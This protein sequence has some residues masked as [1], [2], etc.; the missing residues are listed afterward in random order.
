MVGN[1]P[2]ALWKLSSGFMLTNVRCSYTVHVNWTWTWGFWRVFTGSANSK[3]SKTFLMPEC[4]KK[5]GYR[6][7]T[8]VEVKNRDIQQ[9]SSSITFHHF[10]PD[11]LYSAEKTIYLR[12]RC[13]NL[14]LCMT[15]QGTR[16]A[17]IGDHLRSALSWVEWA[18]QTCL[19]A[20]SPH[21][22]NI[23]FKHMYF[24]LDFHFM[25]ISFFV[26]IHSFTLLWSNVIIGTLS[27]DGRE[28]ATASIK[29]SNVLLE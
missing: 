8:Q 27:S 19:L 24:S 26:K 25:H 4:W 23:N 15:W 6:S 14:M 29:H 12:V 18:F 7:K 1:G 21:L 5:G 22:F 16:G 17:E 13:W 9:H 11:E 3:R 20:L 10:S 28:T 2:D